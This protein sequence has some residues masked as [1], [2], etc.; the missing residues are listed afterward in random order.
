MIIAARRFLLILGCMIFISAVSF[1][2]ENKVEIIYLKGDVSV[3]P[4]GKADWVKGGITMTLRK[5][6]RVKTGASSLC[7]LSFDTEKRMIVGIKGNSDVIVLLDGNRKIELVAASIY[8][9]LSGI[10]KGSSFEIKTPTAVCGA[11]GTGLGVDA[12]S[13]KTQATAYENGIYVQND[14]G[15]EKDV[16]EGDSRNIDKDGKI[17]DEFPAD[18]SDIDNFNSWGNAAEETTGNDEDSQ[19][20][21]LDKI[22][23]SAE[24]TV[25]KTSDIAEKRDEKNIESRE[26]K[27][28]EKNE[29]KKD[30]YTPPSEDY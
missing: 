4:E 7:D 3:L 28:I 11:R 10:P 8:A 19:M 14:K 23:D 6:D 15:E 1:A 24:K 5:G 16:K 29:G 25:E 13:E 22:G 2:F 17:S 21:K 26:E 9:K 18:K 30:D 20:N 12:D 27:G